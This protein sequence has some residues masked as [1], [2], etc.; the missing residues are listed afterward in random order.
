[1]AG[2]AAV[3]GRAIDGNLVVGG[4]SHVAALFDASGRLEGID[5]DWPS[6]ADSGTS[7][8]A[9]SLDRIK[10]RGKAL[11][12][13]LKS[14]E[15][16]EDENFQCGYFDPGGSHRHGRVKYLQLGCMRQVKYKKLGLGD[17]NSERWA[18]SQALPA[19]ESPL[20]DEG[21]IQGPAACGDPAGC[22]P[23]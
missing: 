9:T 10:A 13:A 2:W 11:E 19:S 14:D 17:G 21:W 18:L 16:V 5:V 15:A 6:Y 12:T 1:V 22:E 20:K 3:H 7:T 4:G 23:K 8:K